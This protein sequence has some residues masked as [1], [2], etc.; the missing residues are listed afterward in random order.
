MSRSSCFG[1]AGVIGHFLALIPGQRLAQQRRQPGHF[2]HDRVLQRF[3][4]VI[5]GQMQQHPVAG[6][7]LDHR[8]DRRR[9]FSTAQDEV[10]LRKTEAGPEG[11]GVAEVALRCGRLLGMFA[12]LFGVPWLLIEICARSLGYGC[13]SGVFHGP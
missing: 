2:G 6:G 7:S 1:D 13:V 3:G 8:A 9:G 12:R 4:G 10:T 11:P 5:V